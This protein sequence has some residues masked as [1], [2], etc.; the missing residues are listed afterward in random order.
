MTCKARNE[1]GTPEAGA[2][3]SHR[4]EEV[5]MVGWYSQGAIS[6]TDCDMEGAT[7]RWASAPRSG[8]RTESR[9][10][11]AVGVRAHGCAN[12]LPNGELPVE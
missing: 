12:R 7:D 8:R 11:T 5:S 10:W 2:V 4:R 3:L 1:E 9:L 6:S